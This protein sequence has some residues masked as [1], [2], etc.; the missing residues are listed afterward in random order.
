M[1]FK[2]EIEYQM[3]PAVMTFHNV[4][5]GIVKRGRF[6]DFFNVKDKVA[7]YDTSYKNYDF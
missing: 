1:N 3:P 2:K 7:K 4:Q 6:K 5:G